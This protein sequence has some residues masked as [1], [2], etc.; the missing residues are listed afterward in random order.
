VADS[1]RAAQVRV[2]E[3]L[4][5]SPGEY[6]VFNPGTKQLVAHFSGRAATPEPATLARSTAVLPLIPP[7]LE[8]REIR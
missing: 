4:L 8:G 1:L 2:W 6:I 3:L 5:G 7:L